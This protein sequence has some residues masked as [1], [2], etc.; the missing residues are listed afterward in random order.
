MRLLI[1]TNVL[2]DYL[3]KREP[4]LKSAE[5]IV[6]ACATGKVDGSIA[7]HSFS[8]IF[9]ILRNVFRVDERKKLLLDLCVLF[10]VEG[11]NQQT[12]ETSLRNNYFDDFEDCL[13]MECAISIFVTK[14]GFLTENRKIL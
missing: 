12:I 2:L 1:D 13:Q 8:N 3:A 14:N 9:Y 10:T 5:A 6:D 11:I 4:F 7:A